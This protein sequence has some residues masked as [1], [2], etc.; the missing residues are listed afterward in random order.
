MQIKTSNHIKTRVLSMYLGRGVHKSSIIMGNR[1]TS[2][3]VIAH[4]TLYVYTRDEKHLRDA[5]NAVLQSP[6]QTMTLSRIA[7]FIATRDD[8]YLNSMVRALA[9]TNGIV[10]YNMR[11]KVRWM[12]MMRA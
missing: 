7:R 9:L 10:P 12:R 3:A 6:N 2:E 1:D 5:G 11:R 4:L 8:I